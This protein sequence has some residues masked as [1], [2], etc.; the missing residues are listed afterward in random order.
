LVTV[1]GGRPDGNRIRGRL[2]AS[3]LAWRTELAK[4]GW[5]ARVVGAGVLQILVYMRVSGW[6]SAGAGSSTTNAKWRHWAGHSGTASLKKV[7][8]SKHCRHRRKKPLLAV[9]RRA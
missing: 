3:C 7:P 8:G 6:E 1:P 9:P 4:E 5:A 2:G